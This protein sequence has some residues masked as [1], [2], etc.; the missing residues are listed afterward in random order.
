MDEN[1][2]LEALKTDLG[3]KT[4]AYNERL[5]Q[6]LTSARNAIETEG[7]ELTDSIPDGNLVVMYAGWLWRKRATGEGM[8]RNLR[9]LMNNRLFQGKIREGSTG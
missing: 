2:M 8:P 6:Y 3:I 9:W 7:I 1:T 4:D 5:T